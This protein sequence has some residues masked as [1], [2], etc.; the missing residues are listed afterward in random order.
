MKIRRATPPYFFLRLYSS[1]R[2]ANKAGDLVGSPVGASTR[3][4][5]GIV[6]SMDLWPFVTFNLNFQ[7]HIS[8]CFNNEKTKV[9]WFD[10][11]EK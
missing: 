9:S 6:N 3:P 7:G 4:G 1:T 8:V 10:N 5:G 2:A 11:D